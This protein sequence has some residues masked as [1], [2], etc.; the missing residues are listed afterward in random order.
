MLRAEDSLIKS[1]VSG[2]VGGMCL[3][4]AGHPLDLVKVRLQTMKVTRGQAPQYTGMFD[5]FR[6]TIQSDGVRLLP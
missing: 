2:G 5:V 4:F 3:V 6:K 1:F